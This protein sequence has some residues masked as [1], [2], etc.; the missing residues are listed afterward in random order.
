MVTSVFFK[1]HILLTFTDTVD[2]SVGTGFIVPAS[3]EHGDRL[4]LI[5][6]FLS[7]VVGNDTGQLSVM[8]QTS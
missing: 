1:K 3:G 7:K 4:P 8:S 5:F 2:L 6:L